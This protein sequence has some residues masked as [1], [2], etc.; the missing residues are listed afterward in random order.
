M[1]EMLYICV[2]LKCAFSTIPWDFLKISKGNER[3]FLHFKAIIPS[4]LRIYNNIK[5]KSP[6]VSLFSY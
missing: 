2:K 1:I 5:L 6:N 4:P 3:D